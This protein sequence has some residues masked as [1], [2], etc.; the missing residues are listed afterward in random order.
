ALKILLESRRDDWS[1]NFYEKGLCF[2]RP[3][4]TQENFQLRSVP[5]LKS[6]AILNRPS[7]TKK[8][9][10]VTRMGQERKAVANFLCLAWKLLFHR[11]LAASPLFH[12]LEG[13]SSVRNS[14]ISSAE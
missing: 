11:S 5:G 3:S 13:T 10:L 9:F 2:N 1:P 6:W 8:S 14:C 7:G 12:W 4:G